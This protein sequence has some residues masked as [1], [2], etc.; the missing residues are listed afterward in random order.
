MIPPETSFTQAQN[1]L[2]LLLLQLPTRL[3]VKR[4]NRDQSDSAHVAA[5]DQRE[6][7]VFADID[8]RYGAIHFAA[9]R[10]TS[11]S[12]SETGRL[13]VD[14]VGLFYVIGPAKRSGE[15]TPQEGE[16]ADAT[17]L[18]NCRTESERRGCEH[19]ATRAGVAAE[20]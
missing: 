17:T 13:D 10:A 11:R 5:S 19:V 14:R 15:Q 20:R 6:G 7:P 12:S 9:D 1:R 16:F 18:G 8:I 4:S 3:A 2:D